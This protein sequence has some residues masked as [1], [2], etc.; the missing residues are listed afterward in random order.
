V[1]PGEPEKA[2]RLDNTTTTTVKGAGSMTAYYKHGF[3]RVV[4]VVGQKGGVGKSKIGETIC[5]EA[6]A[7]GDYD[8]VYEIDLDPNP[9]TT[10]MADIFEQ[11]WAEMHGMPSKQLLAA[12][13]ASPETLSVNRLLLHPE[14][15]VEGI[16]WEMPVTDAISELVRFRRIVKHTKA[17][18]EVPLNSILQQAMQTYG[19]TL[20]KQS[21]FYVIP[22]TSA[23][24]NTI[25]T[26]EGRGSAAADP[27]LMLAR[28]IDLQVQR[29]IFTGRTLIVIDTAGE[30][31]LVP[32][33]ADMAA[34]VLIQLFQPTQVAVRGMIN[35]TK[36][37]IRLRRDRH[38]PDGR[39]FLLPPLYNMAGQ[40][41][42]EVEWLEEVAHDLTPYRLHPDRYILPASVNFGKRPGMKGIPSWLYN[43]MDPVC[44]QIFQF[45]RDHLA[46][47]V[48]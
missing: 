3:P 24:K 32:D 28:A 17:I 8:E 9:G 6:A 1:L 2:V 41:E 7:R 11:Q 34:D 26:I 5:F 48:A 23:L 45:Y 29:G 47:E 19:I 35:T 40:S 25:Q 10:Q 36:N 38:D 13:E 21:P 44:L 14:L 39:P 22:N 43:P 33:S 16:R 15:G 46:P 18:D 4:A 42:E 20:G 37:A 12:A 31:G 30:T 27:R